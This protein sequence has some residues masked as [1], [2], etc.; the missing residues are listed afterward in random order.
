M[1]AARQPSG[2]PPPSRL[3]C[4]LLLALLCIAAGGPPRVAGGGERLEDVQARCLGAPYPLVLGTRVEVPTVEVDAEAL[5]KKQLVGFFGSPAKVVAAGGRGKPAAR[6]R[7]LLGKADS[8]PLQGRCTRERA[9]KVSGRQADANVLSACI[10]DPASCDELARVR[11]ALGSMAGIKGLAKNL[12]CLAVT[13]GCKQSHVMQMGTETGRIISPTQQMQVVKEAPASDLVRTHR[14]CALVGNG[15]GLMTGGFK[16]G[17]VIDKHDAVFKFNLKLLGNRPGGL[18]GQSKQEDVYHG[19]RCDYR[20]INS[21]R[22][23]IMEG[24]VSKEEAL[25]PLDSKEHWLFWHYKTSL[26]YRAIK[27]NNPRSY[28][29]SPEYQNWVVRTYFDIRADLYRAGVVSRAKP[30]QCPVNLSSGIHALWLAMQMCEVTNIFGF[31]WSL[32]MLAS[33]TDG[34]SPRVTGSHSWDF[35][36]MVLKMLALVGRINICTQ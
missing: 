31:S 18:F 21:K 2:W 25:Q 17:E 19:R 9:M 23:S 24:Q 28:F 27:A 14:T 34:A 15:P 8:M 12:S 22:S 5:R 3:R 16:L 32:H 30:L 29:L 26:Y 33:R 7:G 35:D 1:A 13:R 6:G 10:A 20:I 11:S 4:L 36:T